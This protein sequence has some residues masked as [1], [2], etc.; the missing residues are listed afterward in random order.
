MLRWCSVVLTL[1]LACDPPRQSDGDAE[2]PREAAVATPRAEAPPSP[3]P[4][5]LAAATPLGVTLAAVRRRGDAVEIEVTLDRRLPP[6][7]GSRPTLQIGTQTFRRSR[8]ADG[9]L[10][11]LV[12]L[13]SAAELDALP[14]G[15]AIVV[16]DRSLSSEAMAEPPRLDKSKVVVTP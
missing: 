3:A 6:T 10:D 2:P 12:F 11:R 9:A 1:L 8:R 4:P 14:D 15:A 5:V 13:L 16:R 7:G